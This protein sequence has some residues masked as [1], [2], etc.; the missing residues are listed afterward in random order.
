MAELWVVVI[1]LLISWHP[2]GRLSF[3]E[4]TIQYIPSRMFLPWDAD[5][6]ALKD[7]NTPLLRDTSFCE[8]WVNLWLQWQQYHAHAK[9]KL[10]KMIYFPPVHLRKTRSRKLVTI[11]G[12]NQATS[13]KDYVYCFS[14]ASAEGL[15]DNQHLWPDAPWQGFM[16]LS[17]RET[18]NPHQSQSLR[19][20][21]NCALY[22]KTL[23]STVICYV[24]IYILN[25]Y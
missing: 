5:A 13:W 12:G 21:Y 22:L 11:L 19:N 8:S 16:M 18:A 17:S 2:C 20:K 23:A 24:V 1:S 10:Q 15:D 3:S 14:R 25:N 6:P 4:M 7:G 9:P